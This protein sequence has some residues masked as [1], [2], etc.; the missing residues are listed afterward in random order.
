MDREELRKVIK[1]ALDIEKFNA[2][3]ENRTIKLDAIE[4]IAKRLLN[5]EENLNLFNW[6]GSGAWRKT[7]S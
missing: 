3:T 2:K 7:E 1:M 4:R 6:K 5:I